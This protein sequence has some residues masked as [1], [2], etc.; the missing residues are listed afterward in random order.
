[1]LNIQM[2]IADAVIGA[3]DEIEGFHAWW[4]PLNE[5]QSNVV[6]KKITAAVKAALVDAEILGD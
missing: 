3:L 1:M 4:G 2:E 5:R 6:M